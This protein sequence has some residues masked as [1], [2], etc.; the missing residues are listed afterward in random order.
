MDNRTSKQSSILEASGILQTIAQLGYDI[1][2]PCA[3]Q[4]RHEEVWF[5]KMSESRS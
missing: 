5:G 4:A 1:V 2:M 3:R